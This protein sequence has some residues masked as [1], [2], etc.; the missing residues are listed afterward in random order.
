[1]KTIVTLKSKFEEAGLG[2]ILA[3]R[4]QELAEET[5][6]ARIEELTRAIEEGRLALTGWKKQAAEALEENK[7]LDQALQE[8]IQHK[9]EA[10]EELQKERSSKAPRLEAIERANAK[11]IEAE[12]RAKQLNEEAELKHQMLMGAENRASELEEELKEATASY[13]RMEAEANKWNSEANRL[14]VA[15][16]K[17]EADNLDIGKKFLELDRKH[18]ELDKYYN[19]AVGVNKLW[20]TRMEKAQEAQH[21][22]EEQKRNTEETNRIAASVMKEQI[23]KIEELEAKAE[24]TQKAFESID[25]FRTLAEA[26]RDALQVKYSEL[27]QI[28]RTSVESH[29][30]STKKREEETERAIADFEERY[31]AA[32]LLRVKEAE[33]KAGRWLEE[34]TKANAEANDLKR[35]VNE[36]IE[37]DQRMNGVCGRLQQER[38]QFRNELRQCQDRNVRLEGLNKEI[39]GLNNR[40]ADAIREMKSTLEG[41][42]NEIDRLEKTIA[43]LEG[44]K[45]KEWCQV[46]S[47]AMNDARAEIAALKKDLVEAKGIIADNDRAFGKTLA[48][49]TEARKELQARLKE[50]EELLTNEMQANTTIAEELGRVGG[51]LGPLRDELAAQRGQVTKLVNQRSELLEQMRRDRNLY[52]ELEEKHEAALAQL[53]AADITI[54]TLSRLLTVSKTK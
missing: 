1:M 38:D 2:E 30:I 29:M 44:D 10:A 41:K 5:F 48:E 11:A 47:K 51:E 21:V 35:K 20:Q 19:N 33:R 37:E 34:C 16:E 43:E 18:T 7:R 54:E 14:R 50:S 8:A 52:A 27:D 42:Y 9:A 25:N 24:E 4:C 31:K 46:K 28:Y 53:L 45:E 6:T 17:L 15:A 23:K 13:T 32:D 49:L 22:A 3:A 40:Q 36:L 12:A 26:E 39:T